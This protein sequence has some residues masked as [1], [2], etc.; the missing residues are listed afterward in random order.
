MDAKRLSSLRK[1]TASLALRRNALRAYAHCHTL[2]RS[3]CSRDSLRS[4]FAKLAALD[5]QSFFTNTAL[6]SSAPSSAVEFNHI[7]YAFCHRCIASGFNKPEVLLHHTESL[8]STRRQ[9][10]V[11]VDDCADNVIHMHR[12]LN[13]RNIENVCIWWPPP[14][15]DGFKVEEIHDPANR[16]AL[17]A[18]PELQ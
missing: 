15:V 17:L 18:A 14:H 10:I 13:E 16:E 11:F 12:F 5:I 8:D 9:R 3:L 6:P 4:I 7:R 1:S 2:T